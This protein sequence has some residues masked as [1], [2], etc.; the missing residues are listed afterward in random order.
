[1]SDHTIPHYVDIRE[2]R[3]E[4]HQLVVVALDHEDTRHSFSISLAA[5]RKLVTLLEANLPLA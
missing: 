3:A 2:L 5:A 4:P 1:M